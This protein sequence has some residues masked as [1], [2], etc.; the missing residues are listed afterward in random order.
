MDTTL[1]DELVRDTLKAFRPPKMQTPSE[2]ADDNRILVSESSSEVGRWHTDRAPYQRRVMDCFTDDSVWKIVLQSSS[3]VGKTEIEL[4]CLGRAID[5]DPGP[6][7]YVQ[8][9]KDLA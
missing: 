1:L 7:L 4:N 6:M 9:T 8:P 3:Q 2:W 5:I